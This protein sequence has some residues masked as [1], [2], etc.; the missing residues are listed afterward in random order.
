MNQNM[1]DIN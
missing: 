1:A